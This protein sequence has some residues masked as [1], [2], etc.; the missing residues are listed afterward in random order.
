M[1]INL[2]LIGKPGIYGPHR[3]LEHISLSVRKENFGYQ[4]PELQCFL[5]VKEE[6]K[7]WIFQHAILDA[8]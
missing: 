4:G 6:S 1:I 5:K 2:D 7:V 3:N 8:K